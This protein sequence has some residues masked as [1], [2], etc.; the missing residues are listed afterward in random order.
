MFFNTVTPSFKTIDDV[1]YNEKTDKMAYS[2]I[3]PDKSYSPKVDHNYK[4]EKMLKNCFVL[5]AVS[6]HEIVEYCRFFVI[7][8]NPSDFPASMNV[9]NFQCKDEKLIKIIFNLMPH[10]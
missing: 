4:T 9:P 5:L 6:N 3:G 1:L 10:F 8:I 7:L 2:L